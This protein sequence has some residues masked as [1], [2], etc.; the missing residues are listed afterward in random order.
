MTLIKTTI[1]RRSFL[2]ASAMAGGGF[3]VSWMDEVEPDEALRQS[4]PRAYYFGQQFPLWQ[5]FEFAV[6]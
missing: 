6:P 3:A 2:K 5:I 1:N 4:D